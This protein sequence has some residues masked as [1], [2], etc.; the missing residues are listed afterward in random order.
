[1]CPYPPAQE[2]LLELGRSSR[3]QPWGGPGNKFSIDVALFKLSLASLEN[4]RR[5]VTEGYPWSSPL[6][7]FTN[8]FAATETT[9][10]TSPAKNL[11]HMA[12]ETQ[13][14]T[15]AWPTPLFVLVYRAARPSQWRPPALGNLTNQ[16]RLTTFL[17]IGQKPTIARRFDITSNCTRV[18]AAPPTSGQHRAGKFAECRP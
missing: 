1:M 9:S 13:R 15:K 12:V 16:I 4:I 6:A 8:G 10:V 2:E 3:L 17:F 7:G 5:S 11:V 18:E 14:Q